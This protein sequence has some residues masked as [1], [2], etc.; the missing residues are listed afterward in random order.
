[1]Y[2]CR[3][4]IIW[5]PDHRVD[6]N[7]FCSIPFMDIQTRFSQVASSLV[8][9]AFRHVPRARCD[10]V[11]VFALKEIFQVLAP[12]NIFSAFAPKK[13]TGWLSNITPSDKHIYMYIYIVLFVFVSL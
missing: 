4:W 6:S 3:Y 12:K 7:R 5:V 8:A 11:A 13:T 9:S 2:I 10:L 1:M